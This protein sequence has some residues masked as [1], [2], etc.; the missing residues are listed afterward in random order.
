MKRN[1]LCV[2]LIAGLSASI[3]AAAE[4][5]PN[6]MVSDKLTLTVPRVDFDNIPGF[7]QEIVIEYHPADNQWNLLQSQR[8]VL[9]NNIDSVELIVTQELPI[10]AFLEVSGTFLNG[11]QVL[12]P[13]HVQLSESTFNV[14]IYY[15][16]DSLTPGEMSICTAEMTNFITIVPL[17]IYSFEAGEY[18]YVVNDE[19]EG[20]FVLDVS[21]DI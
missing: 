6:L 11:C 17:S 16:Y 5:S 3:Q 7:Y 12:G 14:A 10:Q 2:L 19:F 18:F 15:D 13:V 8:G 9:I 20:S 21:N 4:E 1:I